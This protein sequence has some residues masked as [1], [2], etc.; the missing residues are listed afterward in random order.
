MPWLT[1]RL[2]EATE[3][4]ALRLLRTNSSDTKFEDNIRNLQTKFAS[5]RL[6]R[7][8][9]KIKSAQKSNSQTKE[10]NAKQIN[11]F[12]TQ[13]NPAVPNLKTILRE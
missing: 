6:S 5:P 10:R 4:E 2:E 13:Y 3:G 11:A 1:E 9:G 7:L 8:Y 12:V